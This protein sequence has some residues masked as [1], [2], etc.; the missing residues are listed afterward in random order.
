M[1]CCEDRKM[2]P[3]DYDEGRYHIADDWDA[4]VILIAYAFGIYTFV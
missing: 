1:T 3:P 4:F 2:Q